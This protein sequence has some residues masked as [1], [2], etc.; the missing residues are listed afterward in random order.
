MVIRF[1]TFWRRAPFFLSVFPPPFFFFPLSACRV[2]SNGFL[3]D[4][5][6][7]LTGAD[8]DSSPI[9]AGDWEQRLPC[10]P[11]H[12]GSW[13]LLGVWR[14]E[15]RRPWPSPLPI[16]LFTALT[17]LYSDPLGRWA[18]WGQGSC[19]SCI[20]SYAQCLHNVWCTAGIQCMNVWDGGLVGQGCIASP[21]QSLTLEP[22]TIFCQS[23]QGNPDFGWRD[24]SSSKVSIWLAPELSFSEGWAS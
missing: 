3:S 6:P 1:F 22:Q 19:V 17:T 15:K 4:F 18:P 14:K 2:S 11:A 13:L 7:K 16:H 12:P 21:G 8:Q 9:S 23:K 24:A 5:L 20:S 10:S